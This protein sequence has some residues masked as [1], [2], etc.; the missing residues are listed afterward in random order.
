MP[1]ARPDEPLPPDLRYR[2]FPTA[3]G[4]EHVSRRWLDGPGFAA[5]ARG[6][7]VALGDDIL[8]ATHGDRIEGVLSRRRGPTV[9]LG[10]SAA[11]AHGCR[12]AD[13]ADPVH[14]AGATT[15]SRTDVV[16]H[17]AV[18][19]PGD[20]VMTS[21]GPATSPSRTAVDLARGLGTRHLT[22]GARVA[23]VDAL[24]HA[25]RLPVAEARRG[26]TAAV[27][28]HGL[29]GARHVL[30]DAADGVHSPKETELRLLV[31]GGG[32]PRPLTQCP[33]MLDGRV[34]ARLDLGW[35]QYR[36]GLEYDGAVHRERDRHSKD[37]D[38]HNGIRVAEWT[39]L[40]VDARL[41]SRPDRLLD[42]LAR[43]VPRT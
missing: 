8:A 9:L 22:H 37:L 13:P 10:P 16:E 11:W 1:R 12:H 4:L 32:F 29:R 23:W 20:V 18:L 15:R 25:A 21:W 30:A 14:L 33:V 27:G 38:R 3:I 31:I 41:L 19:R 42:R 26:V 40:Q 24:L 6:T 28:L 5:V 36:V 35:E 34:I 17:R 43:L 7:R 39:V 2:A